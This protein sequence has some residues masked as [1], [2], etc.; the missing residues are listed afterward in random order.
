VGVDVLLRVAGF[1]RFHRVV[2]SVPTRRAAGL[3]REAAAAVVRGVDAAAGLYF[4]RAWC[5]QRSAAAACL[6]RLH[7]F[8][9]ELVIGVRRMPFLAHAWVEIDGAV[10]NDD[11][12]VRD[13]HTP[14]ERC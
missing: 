4:K 1:E 6:L 2:R 7:G 13:V 10:V 12:R 14:I 8:P 5:L 9:A 3:D 11:P